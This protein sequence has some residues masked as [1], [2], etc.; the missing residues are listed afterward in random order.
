MVNLVYNFF[1]MNNDTIKKIKNKLIIS[2]QASFDEPL[3]DETAMYAMIDTVVRLGCID[4]LRLAGVRDVKYAKGKFP[5]VVIIGIT[6]PKIIPKNYKELV[7]ITPT[8]QDAKKII[9]AGADIIAFDGTLRN[10][11]AKNIIDIIHTKNRLA[12]ADIATFEDAKYS[13]ELGADIISTTLSGYTVESQNMPD[14]PD[15]KLL[16]NCVQKI[17]IPVILEGKIWTYEDVKVAF[18]LGAHSVVIGSAVTR[19]HKIIERLK[20]GLL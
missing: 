1:G 5:Q 14:T 4:T 8:V 7:Y 13:F 2:T 9:D 12:M 10:K 3:Y 6:K 11:D 19:P 20:R 17:G 18:E 16:Q 15:F